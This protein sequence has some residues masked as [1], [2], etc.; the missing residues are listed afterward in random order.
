[1]ES[2]EVHT[3]QADHEPTDICVIC[4]DEEAI[5]ASVACG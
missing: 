5:M 3:P 1:M 2:A 4:Q